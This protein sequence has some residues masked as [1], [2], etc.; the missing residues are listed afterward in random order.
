MDTAFNLDA[1]IRKVPD[2]PKKGILFYD[3]TSILM[4]PAAFAHCVSQMVSRYRS[5]GLDA[6]AAIEAR[7]FLF[8]A[9][10]AL[11]LG[12]PLQLVR[13]QG[14]LPGE[15]VS[16]T[17]ELEYGSD[18]VEMHQQDL[19]PGERVLIVDDLIATGGTV[20]ATVDLIERAGGSVHE[21]FCVIGLPF[22]EYERRLAPVRVHT[23]LNY[24]SE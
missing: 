1:V 20:R 3:I 15:T 7:G 19:R 18:T 10:L 11:D 24:D 21:V 14:K 17:Y 16:L 5:A 2:F 4:D 23:L 22:L 6:I 13:K 8:G 12:L 9:P